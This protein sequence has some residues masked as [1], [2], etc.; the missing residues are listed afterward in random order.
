MKYYFDKILINNL[1]FNFYLIDFLDL[2]TIIINI[3]ITSDKGE[4]YYLL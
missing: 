1:K 3:L 4:N 2:K